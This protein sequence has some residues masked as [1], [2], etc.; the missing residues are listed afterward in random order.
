MDNQP[1]RPTRVSVNFSPIIITILVFAAGFYFLYDFS[2]TGG[3]AGP[4]KWEYAQI[5]LSGPQSFE[6]S[7]ATLAPNKAPNEVDNYD[8]P[9]DL[10]WDSWDIVKFLNVMGDNGWQ[11]CAVD[12][13]SDNFGD[14]VTYTVKYFFKRPKQ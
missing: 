13:T 11:L 8:F 14:I 12:K 9:E 3:N 4:S 10:D 7:F 1:S 6:K 2:K 5:M